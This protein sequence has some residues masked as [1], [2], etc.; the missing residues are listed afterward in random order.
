MIKETPLRPL[1]N[2]IT[3]QRIVPR[4][5]LITLTDAEPYRKFKV[6]AVGPGK[7][8][9]DGYLIPLDVKPGDIVVLPGIA[10]NE[11]D[12]EEGKLL[13]VTEDD[14]GWKEEQLN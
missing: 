13:F 14:I 2:R 8:D 9:E 1:G 6:I 4:Q 5:G 3:V 10:A 7:R 11:P 12:H